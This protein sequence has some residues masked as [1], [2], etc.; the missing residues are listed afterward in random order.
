MKLSL[1]TDLSNCSSHSTKENPYKVGSHSYVHVRVT[2]QH[3]R[4]DTKRTRSERA[5]VALETK[6]H[7]L[8]LAEDL[9]STTGK[10][11][12]QRSAL[13][14]AENLTRCHKHIVFNSCGIHNSPIIPN[15]VCEFR[16]CPN[17][18]RRRS[19][20]LQN[21]HLA[22]MEA[23]SLQ[24]KLT[25]VH[26]VLTQKKNKNESRRA[27]ARRIARAFI[28]LQ[29]RGF[30]KEYFRGGVWSLE[31]TKN[32][33]GHHA[34]LH[35]IAFRK[36]FFDVALL[37]DEWR[38][39]TGDSHVLRI[40]RIRDL[41]KGLEE[42]AKYISK[43]ANT[44]KFDKDDLAEF[45]ELKGMRFFGTFG[46]YRK[47]VKNYVPSD[48]GETAIASDFTDLTEGCACPVCEREGL[49]NP[50][51]EVRM[52]ENELPDF[53]RRQELSARIKSPPGRT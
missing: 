3:R 26:L 7:L 25:P 14:L 1:S 17:C 40:D 27:A 42:A 4:P 8:S 19:R 46:E 35:I 20:K 21:K 31:F 36:K 22:P 30:W 48:K 52:S 50:L 49:N 45:I 43:P 18:A 11:K 34:H 12:L 32:E 13:R 41:K 39:I 6:K 51:F 37:R 38:A 29:R 53:L 5:R 15:F 28:K 47:F 33:A 44:A 24:N 23:Y 9:A 2:K 10:G 16:L